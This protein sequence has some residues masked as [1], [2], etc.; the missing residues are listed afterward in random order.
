[1][2]NPYPES[3]ELHEAHLAHEMAH[4]LSALSTTVVSALEITSQ[5]LDSLSQDDWSDLKIHLET[6]RREIDSQKFHAL[7]VLAHR[8]PSFSVGLQRPIIECVRPTDILI[9]MLSTYEERIKRRGIRLIVD[10]DS[11][12]TLPRIEVEINTMRRV[13]HNLL[14]NALKYS[15]SGNKVARHIRIWARRHDARGIYWAVSIQNYGIGFDQEEKAMLFEP[16]FRGHQAKAESTFGSGLGL[17][18]V[19]RCMALH[20]GHLEIDSKPVPGEAYITTATL[21]FPFTTRIRSHFSDAVDSM[22]R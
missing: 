21:V 12:D 14:S 16:G 5:S 7:T 13:Y 6:I 8:L 2:Q 20:G 15:Y 19:Q 9:S 22:G 3:E 1:M 18:D 4:G 11:F 17:S 10:Y